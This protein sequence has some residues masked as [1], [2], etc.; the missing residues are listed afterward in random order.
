MIKRGLLEYFDATTE[1]E[2]NDI[3]RLTKYRIRTLQPEQARTDLRE[4]EMAKA[5]AAAG[6][7]D[8]IR[9]SQQVLPN[10]DAMRAEMRMTEKIAAMMKELG[11]EPV[12]GQQDITR[13]VVAYEG[14]DT[15][16]REAVETAQ[17]LNPKALI[18]IAVQNADAETA[19]KAGLSGVQ[20]SIAFRVGS[21]EDIAKGEAEA[22]FNNRSLTPQ[23]MRRSVL[24]IIKTRAL[25]SEDIREFALLSQMG[26]IVGIFNT[27]KPVSF[28]LQKKYRRY[29]ASRDP[30]GRG[31]PDC[32]I[33]HKPCSAE[34]CW[35]RFL[36]F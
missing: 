16:F 22:L 31:Y 19:A 7:L 3:I 15:R 6:S 18:T 10:Q 34:K 29:S 20:G 28:A 30:G 14:D 24:Q 2:Q 27:S 8:G 17:G 4:A 26:G 36:S 23:E 12:D 11:V 21:V 25:T 35:N 33:T 5:V 9:L 32:R 13:L 1:K